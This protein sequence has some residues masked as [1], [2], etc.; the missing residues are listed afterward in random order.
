MVLRFQQDSLACAERRY[1]FT[2]ALKSV[3]CFELLAVARSQNITLST[4]LNLHCI[5][6]SCVASPKAILSNFDLNSRW[7]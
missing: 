2:G 1:L 7:Q 6:L 4:C 5:N 3:S